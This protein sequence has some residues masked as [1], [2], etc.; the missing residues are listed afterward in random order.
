[1]ACNCNCPY[2][3]T[4]TALT[5]AGV[6]TVTNPNNV[7]NFDKFCLIL[8]INP[9]SVI[10]G[11]PVDYT[12][13]INGTAVPIWD[14]WGYPITTDRLCTR[15]CY[16]GRYIESATPHLTLLNACSNTALTGVA[17]ASATSGS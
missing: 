12:V 15:K 4:T 14:R 7:G 10:T 17:T 8:T 11:V 2:K 1:M 9:D 6:L 5:A 3:H 13:T 16:V